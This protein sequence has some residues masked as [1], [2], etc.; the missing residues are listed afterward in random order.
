MTRRSRARV[1]GVEIT[2]RR[3][4][5]KEQTIRYFMVVREHVRCGKWS[6]FEADW[7]MVS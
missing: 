7:L 1:P 6:G 3:N 2:F 4:R 5:S